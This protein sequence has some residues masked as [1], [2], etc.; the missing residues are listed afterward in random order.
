MYPTHHLLLQ[1]DMQPLVYLPRQPPR[2][3]L[4][5]DPQTDHHNRKDKDGGIMLMPKRLLVQK[6]PLRV[7]VR[8]VQAGV[9]RGVDGL[10]GAII[11]VAFE[12]DLIAGG[13]SREGIF[14]L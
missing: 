5:S 6:W 12:T 14:R 7:E 10:H 3:A 1:Q 4:P 8:E 2:P 9:V 13:I 11:V